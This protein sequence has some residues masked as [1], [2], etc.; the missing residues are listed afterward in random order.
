MGAPLIRIAYVPWTHSILGPHSSDMATPPLNRKL[1]PEY[2]GSAG[3]LRG[4]PQQPVVALTID[5]RE[6][7]I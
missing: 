1:V 6:R 7:R 4:S 3:Q 2:P 5:V